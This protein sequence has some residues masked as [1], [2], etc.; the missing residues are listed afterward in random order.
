ML[1]TGRLGSHTHPI[2]CER[3]SA[4]VRRQMP[5]TWGGGARRPF[6]QV[7][8]PGKLDE[9]PAPLENRCRVYVD[10]DLARDRGMIPVASEK[11]GTA[12]I[13]FHHGEVVR[14]AASGVL[15]RAPPPRIAAGVEGRARPIVDRNELDPLGPRRCGTAVEGTDQ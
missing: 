9:L 4:G 1:P 13:V 14:R 3:R 8:A 2:S 10:V 5:K 12:V 7:S 6:A 11:E 15:V